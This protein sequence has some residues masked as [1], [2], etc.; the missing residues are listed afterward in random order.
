M[1]ALN[2]RYQRLIL[3][4]SIIGLYGYL[5]PTQA[6]MPVTTLTNPILERT[7]S[8]TLLTYQR[9]RCRRLHESLSS[10]SMDDDRRPRRRQRRLPLQPSSVPPTSDTSLPLSTTA[11][12]SVLTAVM[13][14]P[15]GTLW[16]SEWNVT[17]QC[18]PQRPLPLTMEDL[19]SEA[20][21]AIV[22]TLTARPFSLQTANASVA[23]SSRPRDHSVATHTLKQQQRLQQQQQSVP[24]TWSVSRDASRMGIELEGVEWLASHQGV[25]RQGALRQVSLRMAQQLAQAKTWQSHGT[26]TTVSI[27]QPHRPI[28]LYF[29]SVQQALLASQELQFAKRYLQDSQQDSSHLTHITI[30]CSS[31]GDDIPDTMKRPHGQF[32]HRQRMKIM[33]R[34]ACDV[35]RGL[36]L[37]VQPTDYYDAA[38]PPG[39]AIGAIESLQRLVAH[40][41][42]QGLATVVV[43]P[44]FLASHSWDSSM[45]PVPFTTTTTTT[46]YNNG[47]AELAQ[48]SLPWVVRDFM[49]PIYSYCLMK[50]S[51][52]LLFS[53]QHQQE[54]KQ[55]QQRQYHSQRQRRP[56]LHHSWLAPHT[57]LVVQQSVLDDCTGT[58]GVDSLGTRCRAW[59]VYALHPESTDSSSWT[60]VVSNYVGSTCS[61]AGR[62]TRDIIHLMLMEYYQD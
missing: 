32:S 53:L 34:G 45:D 28:A 13:P 33:E 49:P 43:S 20:C 18:T 35:S 37:V 58:M 47:G 62:P 16:M 36:I 23:A 11:N 3:L 1:V 44:R 60:T 14:P 38:Q 21:A 17:N 41:A 50:P 48:G 46:F 56:W 52:S 25:S 8:P 12:G 19:A 24:D 30:L 4:T 55:Q 5:P 59:N 27:Q 9:E 39:P 54:Q 31:Q 61:A 7:P 42:L 10:W 15:P 26:D 29:N 6:W 22:S 57:R 40:A 2:D 51:P